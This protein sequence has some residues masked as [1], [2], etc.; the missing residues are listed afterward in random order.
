MTYREYL[1]RYRVEQARVELLAT[2]K[3]VTEIALDNGFSDDRRFILNF[4]KYFDMTP[5]R[6]RKT[7]R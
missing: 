2:E 1:S 6:Y 3:S 4:K 7:K 5:L